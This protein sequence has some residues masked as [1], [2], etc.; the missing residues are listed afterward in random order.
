M[1]TTI[2]FADYLVEIEE[3]DGVLTVK[4]VKDDETVEEFTLESEEGEEAQGGEEDGEIKGFDEF[5]EEDDLGGD[6]STEDLEDAEDDLEDVEE[7]E[8]KLE[9]FQ[10]F[11]TK[12]P[13]SK[14]K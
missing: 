5:G 12:K 7:K 10:S 11:I 9:S 4:A 14:R 13:T 6:E 2:E 8:E 3:I 1:K